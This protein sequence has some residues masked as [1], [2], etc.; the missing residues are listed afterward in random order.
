MAS[1]YRTAGADYGRTGKAV[2]GLAAA[3]VG[4]TALAHAAVGSPW[5]L[6]AVAG[7]LAGLFC[8]RSLDGFAPTWRRWQQQ[9]LAR[10]ARRRNRLASGQL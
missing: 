10:R 2:A 5:V 7:F 4:T 8:G 6:V 1:Y 9:Q 3:T